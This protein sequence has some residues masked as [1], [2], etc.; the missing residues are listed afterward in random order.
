M[1]L[2]ARSQSFDLK[3][4]I[5]KICKLIAQDS[6]IES[7][8][9]SSV[10]MLSK[11]WERFNS[12]TLIANDTNLYLLLQ[13]NSPTVR[14]YAYLGLM[15]KNPDLFFIALKENESDSVNVKTQNG[16][17]RN[18]YQVNDY[19]TIEGYYYFSNNTDIKIK[20]EDYIYLKN[21]YEAYQKKQME[22]YKSKRKVTQKKSE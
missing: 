9:I 22:F 4:S 7:E 10:A 12:L 2:I 8:Y 3:D 15:T 16:C 11:Q 13:H 19:A 14:G 6:I 17:I 21:G 1:S 5:N 18:S 20:E